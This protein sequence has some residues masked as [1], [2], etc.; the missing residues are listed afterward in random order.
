MTK[1]ISFFFAVTMMLTL[2]LY[3]VHNKEKAKSYAEMRADQRIITIIKVNKRF[4][5]QNI[6]KKASPKV[7]TLAR[8]YNRLEKI[9]RSKKS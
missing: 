9:Y 1:C 8:E 6:I 5:P 7:K 2:Q 3:G 4:I